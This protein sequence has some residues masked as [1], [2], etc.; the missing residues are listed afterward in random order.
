[1]S[2]AAAAPLQRKSRQ[3]AFREIASSQIA[4]EDESVTVPLSWQIAPALASA[5]LTAMC[6]RSRHPIGRLCVNQNTHFTCGERM[7]SVRGLKAGMGC[8]LIAGT[9]LGGCVVAPA[10]GY[11]AGGV[12]AVAPPPPQV[13]VVGVAP[14]PGYIWFGGYWD[15]VGGRHVWHAGYWGPGKPGYRWVPHTWVRAGGGWR[16]APGH[17]AR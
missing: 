13:E 15:W 4:V 1:M 16:M 2:A 5:D 9:L 10:P 7:N 17:W 8:L 3:I 12:V 11:Y 6:R 14:T